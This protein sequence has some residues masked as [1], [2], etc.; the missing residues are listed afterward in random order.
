MH[1]LYSPPHRFFVRE[2]SVCIW[3]LSVF[4]K[5]LLNHTTVCSELKKKFPVEALLIFQ[6]SE[7]A[8]HVYSLHSN[9]Y[10]L[11]V[12]HLNL[13]LRIAASEHWEFLTM[14]FGARKCLKE[15]EHKQ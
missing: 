1:P 5:S 6:V 13:V 3:L 15:G 14:E 2:Y 11:N 7:W 10:A 9:S 8:T 12:K 4:Q